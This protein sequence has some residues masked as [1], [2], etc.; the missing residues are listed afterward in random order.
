MIG[1]LLAAGM[2]EQSIATAVDT[3]Q[4]TIH[5]AKNGSNCKYEIGKRI[6]LLYLDRIGTANNSNHR[7]SA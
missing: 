3:S 5:R 4:P 7:V 2:T 6:E 1:D